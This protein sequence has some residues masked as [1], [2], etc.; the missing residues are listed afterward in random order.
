MLLAFAAP[1]PAADLLYVSLSNNTLVTYD[2]T[3][4]VGLTIAASASTFAN[5]NLIGPSDLAFDTSG[6]LYAANFTGSTIS[7]FSSSGSFLTSWS[8]GPW[9]TFLAFQ[10]VSVPEPS[11]YALAAIASGVMAY[12]ARRRNKA[13]TA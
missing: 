3:S 1:L 12:L 7:K 5:T 2:T 4:G 13:R 8:I 10:P 11:T 9:A 6:N